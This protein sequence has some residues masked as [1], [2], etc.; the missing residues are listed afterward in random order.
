MGLGF[1]FL[2]ESLV[3]HGIVNMDILIHGIWLT[4]GI[5]MEH[6]VI[7]CTGEGFD[8]DRYGMPWDLMGCHFNGAPLS[9]FI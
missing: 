2:D 7:S 6:A 9:S 3:I 5:D 1:C 8:V 4:R